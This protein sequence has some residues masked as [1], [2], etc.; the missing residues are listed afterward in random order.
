MWPVVQTSY[1]WGLSPRTRGGERARFRTESECRRPIPV[2]AGGT[3]ATEE[4]G[5][6]I[7]PI[8]VHVGGNRV[9]HNL[10]IIWDVA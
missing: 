4:C 10:M 5:L 8:S 6:G 1:A 9:W 2:H 3:A 7:C